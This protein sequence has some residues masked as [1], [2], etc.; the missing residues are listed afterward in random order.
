MPITELSI[1]NFRSFRSLTIFPGKLTAIIGSNAA[2]K[3]NIIHAFTF[4]RDCA[5]HGLLNAVSLQGG[6]N[7]L[8]NTRIGVSKPFRC[9]IRYHLEEEVLESIILPGGNAATFSGRDLQYCFSLS[10]SEKNQE[11]VILEDN[12]AIQGILIPNGVDPK[13]QSQNAQVKVVHEAGTMTFSL[14]RTGCPDP[15]IRLEKSLPDNRLLITTPVI[16]PAMPGLSYLFGS[17]RVY[18]FDPKLAKRAVPFTSMSDLLENGQNLPVVLDALLKDQQKRNLFVTLIKDLLPFVDEVVIGHYMGMDLFLSL[19]ES[20]DPAHLIPAASISDGTVLITNIVIALFF[21]SNP[22]SILEEPEK[23]LHPCL[24]SRIAQMLRDASYQRQ[25]IIS[26]H[27]PEMV[28]YLAPE[29]LLLVARDPDGFSEAIRPLD[30]DE[31][32]TFLKNQIGIDEL[33]IN[34]LLGMK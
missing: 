10:F 18:D 2:G 8:L 31:V 15:L 23:N 5:R 6:K 34:N 25:I 33:F 7:F 16:F 14:I 19:R 22:V 32:T 20:Y 1:E 28:R 3:S 29:S 27:H 9:S 17:I 21:E 11:P 12:L 13:D 4:I 30:T 24:I 26:T